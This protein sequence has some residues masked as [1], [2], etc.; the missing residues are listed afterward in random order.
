MNKKAFTLLEVLLVMT[1]ISILLVILTRL[2]N[3]AKQIAFINNSQRQADV[4][5]IYT[6][7]NQYRDNNSGK[8]PVGI[9][10]TSI[11]ICQPGCLETSSQIDIS[12]ELQ[13]YI[14]FGIIPI[15]PQNK[16][17]AITGYSVYINNQG[18]I[19]VSA[20]LAEDGESINTLE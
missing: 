6:A 5:T 20:L 12:T 10:T 13:P 18:R 15:D 9:S 19:V 8:S 2:I 11:N 3:P 4:F 17:T 16:N 1:L 7:I 14:S